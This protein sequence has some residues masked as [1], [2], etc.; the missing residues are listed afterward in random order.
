MERIAIPN[1]SERERERLRQKG[2]MQGVHTHV[3]FSVIWQGAKGL[4]QGR[5]HL[6]GIAL[7]EPSATYKHNSLATVLF[8]PSY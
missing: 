6:F 2:V 7:E 8:Y 1:T 5:I 4:V 3:D